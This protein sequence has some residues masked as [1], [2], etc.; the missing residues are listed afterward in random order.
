MAR[1]FA[2]DEVALFQN[3]HGTKGD[4]FQ[5]ADWRGDQVQ[6][7]W[8]IRGRYSTVS[9]TGCSMYLGSLPPVRIIRLK[10]PGL[11]PAGILNLMEVSACSVTSTCISFLPSVR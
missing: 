10:R 5:V 3:P 4:V 11:A 8:H 2:G 9:L 7:T 6:D 1:I